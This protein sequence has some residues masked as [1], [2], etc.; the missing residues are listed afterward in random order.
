MKLPAGMRAELLINVIMSHHAH[1][2]AL[3]AICLGNFRRLY[4]DD[5]DSYHEEKNNEGERLLK[6]YINRQGIYD[7]LPEGLFHSADCFI[8]SKSGNTENGFNHQYDIQKQEIVNAR[9]LFHPIENV[10]FLIGLASERFCE[11]R[12]LNMPKHLLK[13]L[14]VPPVRFSVKRDIP[15]HVVSFISLIPGM[16][17]NIYKTSAFLSML[18]GSRVD[19][20]QQQSIRQFKNDSVRFTN[21]LGR[22]VS[23]DTMLCGDTYVDHHISWVFSIQA[24]D[25]FLRGYLTGSRCRE[26]MIFVQKSLAPAGVE[27]RLQ[28]LPTSW[29]QIRLQDEKEE[30]V[31]TFLGYNTML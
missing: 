29:H 24:G 4:K 31:N 28:I 12:Y 17:G 10:F 7:K 14:S 20:E 19:A 26:T 9:K 5:V 30:R 3:S 21:E 18:F 2:M 27:V 25:E 8:K 16:R 1:D 23:G 6:V 22:A 13:H 15:A 11:A